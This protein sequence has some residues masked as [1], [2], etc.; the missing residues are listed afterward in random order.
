MSAPPKTSR[1]KKIFLTSKSKSQEKEDAGKWEAFSTSARAEASPPTS[2]NEK[3]KTKKIKRFGSWRSKKKPSCESFSF[4]DGGEQ[5][6][7]TSSQI[8]VRNSMK[9]SGVT[10]VFSYTAIWNLCKVVTY[11][12][13][14]SDLKV[15][16]LNPIATPGPLSKDL[17]SI[18]AT[19]EPLSKDLNSI[20]ATHGPLNKDLNSIAATHGPLSKD[21][22][23][24]A[25]THGPL[26]KDLNSIAATH[27]PLSK[28]LISITAT[29]GL[30]SKDINSIA[31]TPGLLS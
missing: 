15:V 5:L 30:L 31:A 17:N 3:K 16:T 27:G 14:H 7:F 25:A 21:L 1:F 12:L 8:V 24:I 18:A 6:D 22:I 29:H 13:K 4:S 19:P 28:D 9:L 20:A 26:S 11:R 2:P 10:S 23:S